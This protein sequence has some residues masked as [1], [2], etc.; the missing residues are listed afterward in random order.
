VP[1]VLGVV[2]VAGDVVLREVV[3]AVV[4]VVTGVVVTGAVVLPLQ[5]KTAG[6]ECGMRRCSTK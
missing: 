1:P 5:L 6:P 4:G 3:G 2:V